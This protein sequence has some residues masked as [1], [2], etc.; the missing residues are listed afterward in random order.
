MTPELRS[1]VLQCRFSGLL[2][3][4]SESRSL[5]QL[6][7]FVDTALSIRRLST[8]Q[9]VAKEE[10]RW[11]GQRPRSHVPKLDLWWREAVGECL[12]N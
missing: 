3:D 4:P 2:A 1:G 9:A 5:R 8:L 7:L 10:R 11:R 6:L 12:T